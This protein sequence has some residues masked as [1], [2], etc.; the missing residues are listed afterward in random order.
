MP[1]A[2]PYYPGNMTYNDL[3]RIANRIANLIL[4]RFGKGSNRRDPHGK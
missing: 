2:L 3:N 1:I 4:E